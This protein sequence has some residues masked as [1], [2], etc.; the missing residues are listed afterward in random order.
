MGC[1]ICGSYERSEDHRCS[2]RAIAKIEN[3]Y[4]REERE[5]EEHE[6]EDEEERNREYGDR[7]RD[8]FL[9]MRGRYE[10]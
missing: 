8:G 2:K 5:A 1:S 3:Q 4:E 10:R 7:L 6:G 9:Q